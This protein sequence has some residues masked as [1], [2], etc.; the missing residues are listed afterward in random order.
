MLSLL[1]M[2]SGG[3]VGAVYVV[4][5]VTVDFVRTGVLNGDPGGTLVGLLGLAVFGAIGGAVAGLAGGAAVGFVLTFL[6]GRDMPGRPAS[7]L[8]FVGAAATVA[9]ILWFVLP[10]VLKAAYQDH[11]TVL[12]LAGA[13]AAGLGTMWFRGQLLD[14]RGLAARHAN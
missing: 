2:T 10:A 1:G 9:L 14:R 4:V 11:L 6:V 7:A 12:V 8:T 5:M 13:V 3:V